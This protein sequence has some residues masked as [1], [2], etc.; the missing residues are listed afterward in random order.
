MIPQAARCGQKK[1]RK[2]NQPSRCSVNISG[3]IETRGNCGSSDTMTVSCKRMEAEKTEAILYPNVG[4]LS[5]HIL[6]LI[7]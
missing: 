6:T 7:W 1:E 4:H 5:F 3:M 2:K